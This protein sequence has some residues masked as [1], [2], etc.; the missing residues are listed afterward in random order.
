MRAT[1]LTMATAFRILQS[2]VDER[3]LAYRA[4]DRTYRVGPLAFELGLAAWDQVHIQDEWRATIEAIAQDSGLT[5]YLVMRAGDEA[6]CL[7]CVAGP[8]RFSRVSVEPGQRAP[9]GYGSTSLALLAT[10]DD[11]AVATIL[12]GTRRRLSRY[13]DGIWQPEVIME[14]VSMTR[15]RGFAVTHGQYAPGVTGIGVAVPSGGDGAHFAISVA[16][17]SGGIS[18]RAAEKIVGIIR[19]AV[20]H[21]PIERQPGPT[22]D[23][24]PFESGS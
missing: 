11:A 24:D 4:E 20:A 3:L 15:E 14:R 7:L 12:E 10:L 17:A 9:L 13:V 6:V 21:R 18:L 23:H 2:L 1:G 5:T 16:I 8:T 22:A 19:N